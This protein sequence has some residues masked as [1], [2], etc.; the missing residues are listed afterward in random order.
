MFDREHDDALNYDKRLLQ[1]L[2]NKVIALVLEHVPP[3]DLLMDSSNDLEFCF[4]Y[5]WSY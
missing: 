3:T 4:H 2:R 5:Y 1:H